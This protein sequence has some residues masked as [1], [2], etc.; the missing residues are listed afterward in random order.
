MN[1][2]L[3]NV[4]LMAHLLVATM[5]LV[6]YGTSF[7][8]YGRDTGGPFV[9]AAFICSFVASIPALLRDRRFFKKYWG[10]GLIG[11][12]NHFPFQFFPARE[13]RRLNPIA[14]SLMA[15][16]FFHFFW[17]LISSIN[18]QAAETDTSA[19][20]RYVSLMLVAAE[21]LGALV[22]VNPPTERPEVASNAV[23]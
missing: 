22:W 5:G 23:L 7:L 6:L 2:A 17:L 1:T 14:W 10:F 3:K 15:V 18:H 9:V 21:V 11:M 4:V 19:S 20:L 16:L 8:G 13:D 12:R